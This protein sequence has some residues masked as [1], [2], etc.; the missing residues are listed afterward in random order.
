[1]TVFHFEN[2]AGGGVANDINPVGNVEGTI[3]RER[4]RFGTHLRA[5]AVPDKGWTDSDA[6]LSNTIGDA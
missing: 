2:L 4:L 1:M 3:R 6:R 5:A